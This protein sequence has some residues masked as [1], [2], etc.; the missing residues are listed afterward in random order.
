MESVAGHGSLPVRHDTIGFP[1]T[2]RLEIITKALLL[3]LAPIQSSSLPHPEWQMDWTWYEWSGRTRGPKLIRLFSPPL[4]RFKDWIFLPGG[5]TE[6]STPAGQK[7]WLWSESNQQNLQ[8]FWTKVTLKDS[9]NGFKSV[10]L[11]CLWL[12]HSCRWWFEKQLFFRR[13]PPAG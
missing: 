3:T 9:G 2:E 12:R 11:K 1:L 10:D 4:T 8:T 5:C 13:H 6:I 7:I